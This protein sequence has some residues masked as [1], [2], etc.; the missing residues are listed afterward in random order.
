MADL[1]EDVDEN[2]E[3]IESEEEKGG[4]F[5]L[6][7]IIIIAAVVVLL[8]G[9]TCF[10]LMGKGEPETPEPVEYKFPEAFQANVKDTAA[11]RNVRCVIALKLES[12]KML[13]EFE[14]R[15]TEFCDLIMQILQKYRLE[16]LDYVGQNKLRREISDQLNLIIDDGKVLQVFFPEFAIR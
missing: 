15:N 13:P 6:P 7:K 2:E 10:M 5:T 1:L 16:E 14:K 9:G 4:F 3:T 11:T 12:E 8:G